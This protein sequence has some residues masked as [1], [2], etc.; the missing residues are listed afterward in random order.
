MSLF[1]VRE[2]HEAPKVWPRVE[3]GSKMGP[4]SYG[5]WSLFGG[6]L[7]NHLPRGLQGPLRDSLGG[8]QEPPRAPK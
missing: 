6:R 5:Q 4:Q 1:E 8:P 3:K 2:L 7:L